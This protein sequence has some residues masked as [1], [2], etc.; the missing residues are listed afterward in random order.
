MSV[1]G[2]TMRF[3]SNPAA[4]ARRVR[5]VDDCG[6]ERCPVKHFV[7]SNPPFAV[8]AQRGDHFLDRAVSVREPGSKLH[9]HVLALR[10]VGQRSG[11]GH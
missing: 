4:S 6:C 2:D 11:C 1:L 10:S 7:A 5:V 9:H 8:V 3:G